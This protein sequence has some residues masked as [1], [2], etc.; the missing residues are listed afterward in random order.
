MRSGIECYFVAIELLCAAQAYDLVCE[1]SPMNG[2]EGT[3]AAY[4]V[5]RSQVGYMKEDRLLATDIAKVRTL[6]QEGSIVK[7]VEEK[8]G[9][10]Y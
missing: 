6:L 9:T 2:G 10:L 3:R 5:I 8:V 1:K 7:A 4:E